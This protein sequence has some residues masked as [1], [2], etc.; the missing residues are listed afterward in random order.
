MCQVC[1]ARRN[2]RSPRPAARRPQKTPVVRYRKRAHVGT[3][4]MSATH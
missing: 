1:A 3:Q 4:G 2:S